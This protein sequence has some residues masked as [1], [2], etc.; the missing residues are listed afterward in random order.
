[1]KEMGDAVDGSGQVWKI[2]DIREATVIIFLFTMAFTS[3]LAMLRLSEMARTAHH[4][5]TDET[6]TQ[7]AVFSGSDGI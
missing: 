3:L 1:M 4:A 2:H 7:T 5:E 6:K